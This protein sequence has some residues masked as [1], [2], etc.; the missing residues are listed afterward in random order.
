MSRLVRE[1]RANLKSSGEKPAFESLC[2][3][4]IVIRS[5]LI[6][7][8]CPPEDNLSLQLDTEIK[9]CIA[10]KY[11]QHVRVQKK[12]NKFI[13]CSSIVMKKCKQG[14]GS[15]GLTYWLLAAGRQFGQTTLGRRVKE[16]NHLILAVYFGQDPLSFLDFFFNVSSLICDNDCVVGCTAETVGKSKEV[17]F[18]S[19]CF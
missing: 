15:P 1:N 12:T 9:H 2:F 19:S 4:L 13:V 14:T 5:L 11:S 8:K 18:K 7:V 10:Q 3:F 17:A 16:E 6:C